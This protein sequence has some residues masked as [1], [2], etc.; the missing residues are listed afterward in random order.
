MVQVYLHLRGPSLSPLCP[1]TDMII[2]TGADEKM[3][4]KRPIGPVGPVCALR[5]ATRLLPAPTVS[6]SVWSNAAIKCKS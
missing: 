1:S 4:H 2:E 3:N 6:L 5:R